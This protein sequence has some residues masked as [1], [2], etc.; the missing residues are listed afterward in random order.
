ML[1]HAVAREG[2]CFELDASTGCA[3]VCQHV[4]GSSTSEALMTHDTPPTRAQGGNPWP[5]WD[6]DVSDEE[7]PISIG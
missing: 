5:I 6:V 2:D 3:R 7:F 4:E 1:F